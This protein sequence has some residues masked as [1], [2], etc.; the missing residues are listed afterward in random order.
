MKRVKL[1]EGQTV[2]INMQQ[3][4]YDWCVENKKE[5]LLDEW[6]YLKNQVLGLSP[7][8]I[9][10]GSGKK[11]WWRCEKGHS[12]QAAPYI[13][14][15]GVGCPV[16]ANK[17]V[18]EG[19][20][21]LQSNNPNLAT[22]WDAEKNFP[23]T[24]SD[25]L[26]GTNKKYWWV[27]RKGHGWQAAVSIRQKGIG[28][29]V[30][31]KETRVSFPE[32]A[33][34]YYIKKLYTNVREN[35]RLQ[36]IANKELDIYVEDLK[37]AV[38][39]DGEL[40]HEN[41]QKDIE[42]DRL[43]AECGI[44]IIHI[45]EPKCADVLEKQNTIYLTDYSIK[46]LERAIIEVYSIICEEY[47]CKIEDVDIDVERDRINIYEMLEMQEKRNSIAIIKPELLKDWNYVKNG[48]IKPQYVSYGST[49]KYWWKCSI[50]NFEWTA[51]A[52]N[53]VKGTGCPQCYLK[54]RAEQDSTA[55]Q[56]NSFVDMKPRLLFEWDF[57]KNNRNP[58]EINYGANVKCWWKCPEEHSWKASVNQ[59]V[60]GSGCPVC[61]GHQILTGYNDLKTK[62]PMLAAEWDYV[63]NNDIPDNIMPGSHQKAWWICSK[64]K[65]NWMADIHSRV[66]G[67]GCPACG[68]LK[69][70]ISNATPKNGEDLATK[71]PT[72]AE[73]WN[74]NK[75][76]DLNP[77]NVNVGSHRVVWWKGK[78]G[79][80]WEAQIKHRV[81][82][83]G[84]PVCAG[85]NV[86][87]G[88]NDIGTVSPRAFQ[89][90]DVVKNSEIDIYTVPVGSHKKVWWLC[91]EC[92][93][94]YQREVYRE[95]K[96]TCPN[97]KK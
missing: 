89:R 10:A 41:P 29:P 47:G 44:R 96:F 53:R 71:F 43:C 57:Q 25:V 6:N 23:I 11:V 65:N 64:C 81:N 84:C 18:C 86:L 78:C 30:C 45:R 54:K 75:N 62:Y 49:K 68:K 22:E 12:W 32:K 5:Y 91:S 85:R 35:V 31:S 28:C 34:Y 66:R 88:Y 20:N 50:C 92:N 26:F 27:C 70:A 2:E 82:G 37:F 16:C 58:F 67:N 73:E 51:S 94:S 69:I 83:T 7:E 52:I 72:I 15:K 33:V 76:G 42:K 39:Y 59:R 17:T 61:S 90:W 48:T 55:K 40:F 46:A 79:H 87:V 97:C 24:P 93:H 60:N 36:E 8:M 77:S 4:L 13:R 80:E 14:K 74:Y 56:G 63:K 38:E 9:G 3:N 1:N 21:D 19:F 95:I